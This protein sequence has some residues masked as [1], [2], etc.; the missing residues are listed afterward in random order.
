[1]PT[2]KKI[3]DWATRH[4]RIAL[5]II[6]GCVT[7]V[8]IWSLVSKYQHFGYNAIDLGIYNQ[9]FYNTVH[10]RLFQFSIHPHSYL[11]D[12]FELFI[13]L[14]TPVYALWN[15]PIML[16]ILQVL[17][18]TL[19]AWPLYMI[20]KKY[21]PNGYALAVP[22]AWL[23]NPFLWN[24]A[25]FEFHMLPFAIPFILLA[26]YYYDQKKFIPFVL[27]SV[28]S[29]TVREDVSLVVIMFGVLAAVERRAYRWILTPIICGGA[30]FIATMQL[31]GYFNGYGTYKFLSMYPWLGDTF[32]AAIHTVLT[33]PWLL[34]T[35]LFTFNNILLC[36]GLLLPLAALPL[37]KPRALLLTLLV[38]VQL[39]LTGNNPTVVLE[40]HYTALLLPGMFIAAI[41][42]LAYITTRQPME[43]RWLFRYRWLYGAMVIGAITYAFVV[44]SPLVTV[45]KSIVHSPWS[46]TEVSA[47]RLAVNA[48]TTGES[49]AA[50]Y[51]FLAPLSNREHLYSLNYAFLGKKQ[52]SD[53]DYELPD[54]VQRV[55]VDA[56]DFVIYQLQYSD[57]PQYRGGAA[58]IRTFLETNNF[59]IASIN[60]AVVEFTKNATN[61]LGIYSTSNDM[62]ENSTLLQNISPSMK[63]V[64]WKKLA[65]TSST[66]IAVALT[67]RLTNT[68]DEDYHIQFSVRDKSGRETYSTVMPF[69]YGLF[70]LFD[71]PTENYVTTNFWLTMPEALNTSNATLDINVV[72]TAGYLDLDG[73]RSAT[74]VYTKKQAIGPTVTLDY[75]TR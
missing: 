11:G 56:N 32:T 39:F 6:I 65:T 61:E 18:L 50:G 10:G 24:M 12:H 36:I 54:S 47:K 74:I 23:I 49:V 51:D 63:L 59:S 42:S 70:P 17:A 13:L 26:Y 45:A 43:K 75:W 46:M 30:W 62:P 20:A 5:T 16:A 7:L 38:A 37:F 4:E 9:V 41:Y 57:N 35:H 72:D 68:V 73:W 31:T 27:L 19:S 29:L 48:V 22:A 55:V 69:G 25:F 8:L 66:T 44:M 15:S 1:M 21:L 52:Y 3:F 33:K 2:L 67:W 53:Q 60:D 40:T 28:L 34:I 58:R 14:L 71:W 64:G